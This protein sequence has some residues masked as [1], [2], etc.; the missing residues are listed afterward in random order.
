MLPSARTVPCISTCGATKAA[1]PV[2]LIRAPGTTS[3]PFGAGMSPCTSTRPVPPSGLTKRATPWLRFSSAMLM[4][5]DASSSDPTV[6]VDPA[7]ATIPAGLTNHTLPPCAPATVLLT[8][9]LN[10]AGRVVS[11]GTMRLSTV[12]ALGPLK[13]AVL[14]RGRK[15]MGAPVLV[16][17]S[18]GAQSITAVGAVMA[19]SSCRVPRVMSTRPGSKLGVPW[20]APGTCARSAV[21]GAAAPAI[22]IAAT[23]VVEHRR[24][25]L[26]ERRMFISTAAGGC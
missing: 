9:P 6:K 25:Q 26:V 24:C 13:L 14:L 11:V 8:A 18:Y 22:V 19:M 1:L 17:A 15:S 7:P 12:N 21:I 10:W 3:V 4:S 2:A 16:A 5:P 23:A 20:N